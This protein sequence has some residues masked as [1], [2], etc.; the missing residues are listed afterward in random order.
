MKLLLDCHC[1][2]TASGHAYSTVKEYAEEASK[3]GLKVIA[4]TDH[5]PA[6]PGSCHLFHFQ[7]LKVVPNEL[8]GVRILKGAEVNI[9]HENG[10]LD[11]PDDVLSTLDLNIASFHPPCLEAKTE[12]INT[13]TMIHVM[14]NPYIHVI[15][16]PDDARIPLNY[17]ALV[18]A[19]KK[20]HVMLEVN[21]SSL[22][23]GTYRE[24]AW[25]NYIHML[26]QCK[27]YEVPVLVSSDSHIHTDI[28]EFE[29]AIKLLH[30][31]EFPENLI[32]NCSIERFMEQIQNKLRMKVLKND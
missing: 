5:G 26:E 29:F 17:E 12:E 20:Y 28:G 14:K 27:K 10:L 9:I 18:K 19:A 15:G 6:M 8:Y 32:M 1:H 16:H 7:N 23:P 31:T 30:E 22:R 3:K 4:I 21:N 2:T 25:S 24:N 13:Q 11:L